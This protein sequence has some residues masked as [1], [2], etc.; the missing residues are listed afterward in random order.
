MGG[1]SVTDTS[2]W[3]QCSI[4]QSLEPFVCVCVSQVYIG[5][6]CREPA[7]DDGNLCPGRLSLRQALPLVATK[8]ERPCCA[9]YNL[10]V[11]KGAQ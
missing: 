9:V 3:V 6:T 7:G 11:H 10:S 2:G 5:S 1:G 4:A 8:L